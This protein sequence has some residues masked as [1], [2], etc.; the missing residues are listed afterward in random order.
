MD[1]QESELARLRD[2]NARLRELE[3]LADGAAHDLNNLLTAILCYA[4]LVSA[5]LPDGDPRRED[6]AQVLRGARRAGELTDQILDSREPR[7]PPAL[8]SITR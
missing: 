8:T 4:D 5:T 1:D 6:L 3:R 7:A 2:E